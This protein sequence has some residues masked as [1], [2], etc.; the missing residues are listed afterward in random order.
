MV[1]C[2]DVALR[3]SRESVHLVI[4]EH[5]SAD[6][7][8]HPVLKKKATEQGVAAVDKSETILTGG[9]FP[10]KGVVTEDGPAV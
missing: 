2:G 3:D 6:T 1:R 5:A 7:W 9:K 10:G 4:A 8:V